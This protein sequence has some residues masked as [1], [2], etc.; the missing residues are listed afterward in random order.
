[1][2]QV[3]NFFIYTATKPNAPLSFDPPAGLIDRY[4]FACPP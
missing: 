4:K 3:F 1:M 2:H